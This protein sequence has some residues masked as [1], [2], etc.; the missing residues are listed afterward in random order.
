VGVA[1]AGVS[2]MSV[3][4]VAEACGLTMLDA[5]LAKLREYDEPFRILDA[6]P[7]SRDRLLRA[8]HRA[9]L[10]CVKGGRFDHVT[11]WIDKGAS[12]ATLRALYE[13]AYG[14]VVTVGLGDSLND[15][16]LLREVEIPVVVPNPATGDAAHLLRKVPTARVT[17]EI[18][19]AGWAEA[20]TRVLLEHSVVPATAS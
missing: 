12:V 9:G 7:A 13:R 20:V 16:A 8:L 18:G 17:A 10:R 6:D 5:R 1:I 15:L 19:P 3:R 11:G 2:D 4:E 14:D